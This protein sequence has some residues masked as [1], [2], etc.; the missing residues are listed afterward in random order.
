MIYV[1]DSNANILYKHDFP[2]STTKEDGDEYNYNEA[3]AYD[4]IDN[5]HKYRMITA[6]QFVYSLKK[7]IMKCQF[8]HV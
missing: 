3:L 2:L 7:F 4:N 8:F 6:E 1:L 5:N